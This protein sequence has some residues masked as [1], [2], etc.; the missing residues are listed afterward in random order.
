MFTAPLNKTKKENISYLLIL[1]GE[2]DRNIQA[3]WKKPF[4][5]DDTEDLQSCHRLKLFVMAAVAFHSQ[6]K[7]KHGI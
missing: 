1:V 2:K 4:T 5:V 3:S 6:F 7:R